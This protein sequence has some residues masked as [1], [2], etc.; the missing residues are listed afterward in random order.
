M[1]IL[2]YQYPKYKNKIIKK[3]LVMIYDITNCYEKIINNRYYE[4][5][6]KKPIQK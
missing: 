5:K 1:K 3:I 6:S 2:L 4:R